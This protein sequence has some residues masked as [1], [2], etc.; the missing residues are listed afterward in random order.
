M[1]SYLLLEVDHLL[2]VQLAQLFF[3]ERDRSEVAVSRRHDKRATV[4]SPATTTRPFHLT[5]DRGKR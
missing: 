3:V 1:T 4:G 2:L 5:A